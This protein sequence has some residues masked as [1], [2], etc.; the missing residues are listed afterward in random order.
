MV[1]LKKHLATLLKRSLNLSSTSFVAAVAALIATIMVGFY[2]E[3][4]NRRVHHQNQR[5]EVSEKLGLIRAK[6]EGNINSNLQLV[7]GLVAVIM[8]KPDIDQKEFAS[9][10]SGL[11]GDHSQLRNIAGAPDLVIS[12]MYPMEGNEAAIGLDYQKHKNQRSAAMRAVDSKALVLAGPINL[13][14]GGRGIIGR[15]PVFYKN[16][17]GVETLWG[18]VSAVVDADRLYEDSGLLDT[19]LPI[20]IAISGIDAVGSDH[21]VFHGSP[22]VIDNEP[23]LSEVTMPTGSW[24]LAAIPRSGWNTTPPDTWKN[25]T[26]I[27]IAGLMVI[28]PVTIAG[29]LYDQRRTYIHELK[30]RQNKLVKLSERLRLAVNTSKIGIWE[31]NLDTWEMSWDDRMRELYGLSKDI[32]PTHSSVWENAIHPDDREHVISDFEDAV[33]SNRNLSMEFRVMHSDGT[34]LWIKA[35]GAIHKHIKGYRYIVGV[36][37]DVSSDIQMKTRLVDAKQSAESRAGELEQ[38][39]AQMEHNSLHDS[40]TGLPN[41]RY[42]D[43]F[44]NDMR[45]RKQILALLHIDLDR[46][47]QIND[48]LGHAAGDAM[49]I[50]T[51]AILKKNTRNGD[52]V[53]RIGGDEFV[54]AIPNAVEEQRLSMLANGIIEEMRQP[55]PFNGH[56]CRFGASIG[57]A[58]TGDKAI[59]EADRL[60]IDA[61]IA[62]YRAKSEGRNRYEFFSNELKKEAVRSKR[63]ADGILNGLERKE[64]V[65][66]FQAQFDAQTLEIS[67][68]EALAR[69][70]HPT[71]GLLTPDKF[72]GI[73]DDLSVVQFIDTTILE[74]TLW[75]ATRW[76]AADINIPKF[77]VNVSASQLYDTE[78]IE[79]L[80]SLDIEPGTLS[81]ELLESIFLDNGSEI[82][83]A[84]LERIKKAGIDIEID[85]FGTGYASIVSLLRLQPNRLKIDRQLI[86]P[87]VE[88]SSQRQLVASIVD[89]GQSLGIKTVAEGVETFEHAR[90]LADLGCDTL[91]G[92]A[93]CRP[94]RSDDF[95]TFVK[96]RNWQPEIWQPTK[97]NPRAV[98]ANPRKKFAD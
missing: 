28:L 87:I 66:Y 29:Y 50:H 89:I 98:A 60:L 10:S 94:M 92:F 84:N 18:I 39:R 12:L 6:L 45:E 86:K 1:T 23:V 11:I 68:V 4:Q 90:I 31:L 2:A 63:V 75:Q 57:I 3:T 76:K 97:R 77:S 53:A 79:R 78:L 40:L 16:D 38:A 25:R 93:F 48:T 46:F 35:F 71:E 37:W 74:Q 96:S 33:A 43:K 27:M 65:P 42:L 62:L 8:T 9:I 70:D 30:L 91:Q 69:W 24:Q 36:N 83:T 21:T 95:M 19:D 58:T 22:S 67:G 51:A 20:Q 85:D 34:I 82:A 64:F 47:K 32:D 13:M 52:F 41:R 26:I 44:L 7:R 15:Y 14:Q 59:V 56:L 55:V 81:F 80:E 88:S 61:D 5:A 54:I 72:L 49:L 17:Q 73:A